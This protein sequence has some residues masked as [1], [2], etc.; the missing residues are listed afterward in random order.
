MEQYDRQSDV[1][2]ACDDGHAAIVPPTRE[3]VNGWDELGGM[4][5]LKQVGSEWA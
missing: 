2:I 4:S 1:Q 3:G 5:G